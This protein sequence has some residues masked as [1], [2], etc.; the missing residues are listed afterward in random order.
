[1][2]RQLLSKVE[3]VQDPRVEQQAEQA[4]IEVEVD[5]DPQALQAKGLSA[6]TAKTAVTARGCGNRGACKAAPAAAR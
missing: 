4:T 1:M 2:I 3:G 6:S 5:L